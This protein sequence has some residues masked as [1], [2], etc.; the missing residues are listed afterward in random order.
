M[1]LRTYNKNIAIQWTYPNYWDVLALCL[2]FGIIILLGW[3]AKQMTLPFQMGQA[4]TISLSPSHLPYYALRTVLRLLLALLCSLLFTFTIATWAAKSKA[5][6][7]LIIPI[8]DVLQSVPVLGFLAIISTTLIAAFAGSALGPEC[9]A[10]FAIFTAQVWNIALSFYQS[11]STVPTELTEAAAML[12]LSPW[13]RFWRVDVPFAMPGLLW[14]VMLSMSASWFFV[15]ASEAFT[16]SNQTIMLPGIGSYISVAIAQANKAAIGY[17]ILTMFIVILL[18]DQLLFRPLISWAEK[19]KAEQM[20]EEEPPSSWVVDLFQRTRLL[21]YTSVLVEAFWDKFVNFRG[22]NWHR[23]YV[24]EAANPKLHKILVIISY[25]LFFVMVALAGMGTV[26]AIFTSVHWP[27]MLHVIWLGAVT[28]FKVMLLIALCSLV[29]IPIGVWI[30][31]REKASEIV[32]PIVQFLAAFPA[33]LLFPII[34]LAIVKWHLNVNIWTAPLMVLGTQ[35][36]ILFNVIAGASALPKDLKQAAD[37]FQVRGWLWWKRFIL[38]GI[39]PYYVTGAMTAAGGAWNVSIVAEV[40]SWGNTHLAATGLGAYITQNSNS[41]DFPRLA[42]GICI[43]TVFV[44]VINRIVWRP[45]YNLAR[46]RFQL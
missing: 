44:L 39:F 29:W 20:G 19:F 30:G 2:I 24:S 8:I 28:G 43:M 38:P 32:Q 46:E 36:Y 5:A 17:A 25:S 13:Q 21:P 18:Y 42:L 12:Q 15:V 35:W 7:R 40:V 9:V 22:F 14:N 6:E 16:V 23:S 1:K 11:L 34:V 26:R 4:T 31:L 37:N 33:N 45:L 3:G 41:G 27:E 10:I